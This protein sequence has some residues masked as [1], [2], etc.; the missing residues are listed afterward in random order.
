MKQ[1]KSTIL[2]VIAIMLFAAFKTDCINVHFGTKTLYK[3]LQNVYST[4]PDG[5]APVFINHVGR[6]GARHLTSI[7]A[8]SIMFLVLKIA[9]SENALTEVGERLLRMDS[10]LLN[11]EKGNVSFISERGKEE[12]TDIAKRMVQNFSSVF[13]NK[14]GFIK[15][16]TTKKERTK[17]SAKAFLKGLNPDT[18]NCIIN[19]FN[20]N[21]N[22]AFYDISPA[23]KS[24]KE[25][26]SWKTPFAIV[27]NTEKAQKL[28]EDLPKKFFTQLFINKLN[29]QTFNFN[30]KNNDAN[31]SS[32]NFTDAFYDACSI[33][34][35][36]EKEIVKAGYNPEA[37][38]FGSLVSCSELEELNFLSSA[39]DFLLKAAG[40]DE[41][42]IQVKI[43]A[44]LLLNFLN[45]TDEYIASKKTIANLR[46]AH[47]ETIAPFATLMGITGASEPILPDKILDYNTVW[48]CE[49]IIP[50][51]ANIQWIL[52]KNKTTGDFLLKFL[53]NEKEVAINGLN[54]SG[55]AFYYKWNDVRNFY[56]QK[57][58]KLNVHAGDN[59][60][61]FLMNIK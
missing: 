37:L 19:N 6:H 40:T 43:A 8:D 56:T 7:N 25:T 59:M 12:Q 61:D 36:L 28:Y 24:F 20:D 48:K 15:I 16:S 47:A 18:A 55:T 39:D 52:Y 29:A 26:G 50:L 27:Q 13:A 31:Y 22:L 3:P 44:P 41:T 11:V 58:E 9:R 46:F 32:K 14:K 2:F 45:A 10:L 60:H 57:L 21:D 23:Y 30:T 5:Y 54:N 35:S 34:G 4:A 38:N 1:F 17:Q 42:G 33:V 49:N 51:S 53:L